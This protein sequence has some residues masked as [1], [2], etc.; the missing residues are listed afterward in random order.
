MKIKKSNI[1][2]FSF[3]D[4]DLDIESLKQKW[5]YWI[6]IE[7]RRLLKKCYNQLIKQIF[8]DKYFNIQELSDINFKQKATE[9]MDAFGCKIKVELEFV[10]KGEDK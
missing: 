7:K 2:Y 1:I 3:K 8:K 6:G 9:D 5:D 4:I 10:K